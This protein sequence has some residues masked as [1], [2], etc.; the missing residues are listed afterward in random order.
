MVFALL[1]WAT[2][3]LPASANFHSCSAPLGFRIIPNT[4]E[5][6]IGFPASCQILIWNDSNQFTINCEIY[7]N[8][9]GYFAYNL[10]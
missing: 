9:C 8:L 6:N 2:V 7:H 5:Y 3:S 10:F 4:L 1:W